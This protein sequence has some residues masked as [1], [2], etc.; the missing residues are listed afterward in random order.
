MKCSRCDHDSKYPERVKQ[1]GCCPKCLGKFCFEPRDGDP[2]TDMLFKK[3]IEAVSASGGVR[4]GVENLY[5]EVC[6]RAPKKYAPVG[7]SIALFVASVVCAIIAGA[8]P[9]VRVL[10]VATAV[11]AL[12]GVVNLILRASAGRVAIDAVKFSLFYERWCRVHGTPQGVIQR[13]EQPAPPPEAEADLGD[14]SFDRVVIS[15]RARTVDLLLANNFH[16]ENNCAILSADGYPVGPA[17]VVKKM[18]RQN[19]RLQV[20]VLHDATPAGCRLAHSLATGRDW[21]PAG[22]RIIDVGIR[23]GQAKQFFGLWLPGK[24]DEVKPGEGLTAME[25]KWLSSNQLELAAVRPQQ[26]LRWLFKAINSQAQP[27]TAE[28]A[29]A[30]S[31]GGGDV[32]YFVG[33]DGQPLAADLDAAEADFDSF[34]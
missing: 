17:E 12:I 25:A 24:S 11:F 29:A 13:R 22:V 9:N 8:V 23:P 26:V 32:L 7:C 14:Y 33:G 19:P 31:D 34:G 15:D 16:F 5:Y 30:S 18:L 10:L 21:L 4:F 6:R 2:I 27:S 28:G 20:F 3:A 1:S